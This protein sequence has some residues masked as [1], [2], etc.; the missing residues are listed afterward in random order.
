ME[1]YYENMEN[2]FINLCCDFEDKGFVLC[3]STDFNYSEYFLSIKTYCEN[4]VIQYHYFATKTKEETKK[5]IEYI[6]NETIFTEATVYHKNSKII[7][8][9][10]NKEDIKRYFKYY[11]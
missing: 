3:E 5:A 7:V 10:R 4:G 11:K 9:Y 2:E 1:K 6:L 8:T